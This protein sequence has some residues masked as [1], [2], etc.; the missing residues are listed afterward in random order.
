MI[1]KKNVFIFP[2]ISLLFISCFSQQYSKKWTDLNYADDGK[3]YHLL[4]IYLPKIE[5]QSYPVVVLIYGS[6]WFSNNSKGSDMNTIGKA[7]L[8]AGY[9]VVTP[10]H[11]SSSDAIFPAQIHD[12]KVV[13]RYIRANCS[14]YQLD[15]TFIGITGSSSGG[16]LASLTGTSGY[17]KQYTVDT[18]TMNIEGVIGKYAS[19]SS[20]VD[21]VCSW[22]G[23]TDFL[24]MDSCG[25]SMDHNAAKSPESSLIGGAI[26]DNKSKCA[27]ANPITYVDP[28]DPPF[29]IFH[30]DADPL[31]PYC[32]SEILYS[33]LQSA[34]VKSEYILMPGGQHGDGVH[35]DANFEKMIDFFNEVSKNNTSTLIRPLP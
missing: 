27:L 34:E 18:I 20:N 7:L 14:K 35:T 25:S 6:A 30:G 13:I 32:Q 5:K 9:A 12:I 10:N 26:Q 21:A 33:A 24:I 31:V 17:V 15:T 4:D 29:Q 8:N 3:S 1:V 11:R 19:F 16:H 2:F 28:T 22:F 23:P